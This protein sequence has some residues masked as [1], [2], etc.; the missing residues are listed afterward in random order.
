M[1]KQKSLFSLIRV[2][3]IILMFY[4]VINFYFFVFVSM[5][6]G[7]VVT[8]YFNH[9]GEALTEYIIYVLILPILLISFILELKLYVKE[10]RSV[11]E[12]RKKRKAKLS[13]RHTDTCL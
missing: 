1:S 5:A 4:L 9:F 13:E 6:N 7:G 8:V 12:E 3:G 11:Y 10:R 2:S